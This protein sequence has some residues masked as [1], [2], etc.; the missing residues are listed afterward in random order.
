MRLVNAID[1]RLTPWFWAVNGSAGVLAAGTAVA[2]SVAFSIDASLW[3][4]ATCCLLLAPIGLGLAAMGHRGLSWSPMAAE[5]Q[6]GERHQADSSAR[7]QA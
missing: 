6:P 5:T 3:V 1:A 4:G 2:T 7:L